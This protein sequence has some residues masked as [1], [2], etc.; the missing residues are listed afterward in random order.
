MYYA[1]KAVARV[2]AERRHDR[3]PI[4]PADPDDRHHNTDLTLGS[5]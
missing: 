2:I 1:A 4:Q 5:A 3:E